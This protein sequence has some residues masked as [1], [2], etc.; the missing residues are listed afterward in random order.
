[1]LLNEKI[2]DIVDYLLSNLKKYNNEEQ[3]FILKKINYIYQ[4]F[5]EDDDYGNNFSILAKIN[6]QISELYVLL[7]DNENAKKYDNY[8][9]EFVNKSRKVDKTYKHTSILFKKGY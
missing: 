8:Y 9:L 5:F 7:N 2:S 4:V 6:K 1:M 3:I